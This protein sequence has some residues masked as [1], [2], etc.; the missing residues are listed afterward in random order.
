M[1]A[2][3][4]KGSEAAARN[5]KVAGFSFTKGKL[6]LLLIMLLVLAGVILLFTF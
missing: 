6:L 1:N 3:L 5:E 2:M 4:I